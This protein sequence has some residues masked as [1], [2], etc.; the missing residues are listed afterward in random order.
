MCSTFVYSTRDNIIVGVLSVVYSHCGATAIC[1]T[2]TV[3]CCTFGP[4]FSCMLSLY[5]IVAHGLVR[6]SCA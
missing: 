5:R 2:D 4:L 6:F 1:S 3:V